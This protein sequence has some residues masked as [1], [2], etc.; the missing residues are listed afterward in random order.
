MRPSTPIS[1]SSRSPRGEVARTKRSRAVRGAL[2]GGGCSAVAVRDA[3]GVPVT[4]SAVSRPA[5]PQPPVLLAGDRQLGEGAALRVAPELAEGAVG[6]SPVWPMNSKMPPR[7]HWK[8]RNNGA[9]EM[10]LGG[11]NQPGLLGQERIHETERDLS[12]RVTASRLRRGALRVGHSHRRW[13]R[14]WSKR[15][16]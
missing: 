11:Q 8:C 2:C 5:P 3:L 13:W 9:Y 6:I 7:L 1:T 12:E 14:F 4:L 15:T 10:G 16:A